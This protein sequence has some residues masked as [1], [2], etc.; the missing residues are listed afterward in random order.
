MKNTA[1]FLA[2]LALVVG[3]LIVFRYER[4]GV[5]QAV[6]QYMLTPTATREGMSA[7]VSEPDGATSA[8]STQRIALSTVEAIRQVPVSR[9]GQVDPNDP[10][11][12]RTREEANWLD[13]HGYPNALQLQMYDRISNAELNTLAKGGNLVA[14]ATLGERLAHSGDREHG[15]PMLRDA[16]LRGSVYAIDAMAGVY[17]GAGN[18]ADPITARAYYDVAAMRGDYRASLLAGMT[19]NF[20]QSDQLRSSYMAAQIF[21]HLNSD[22]QRLYGSYFQYDPRPGID[23]AMV[24]LQNVMVPPKK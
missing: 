22:R 3:S 20:S 19:G 23:A 1:I 11:G 6:Q 16:I 10:G 12:A 18:N 21:Q 5:G 14:Q 24:D 9:N 8:L 17:V 4:S 15:I 2:A 7:S 13:R